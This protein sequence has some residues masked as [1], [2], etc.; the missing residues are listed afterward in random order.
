ML[1]RTLFA[2]SLLSLW[3]VPGQAEDPSLVK[4]D[5]QLLRG[6]AL[7]TDGPALLDLIRRRTLKEAERTRVEEFIKSW[8]TMSSRPG[9]RPRQS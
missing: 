1:R 8:P 4:A 7:K 9:R 2:L 6:A 5:E 3:L